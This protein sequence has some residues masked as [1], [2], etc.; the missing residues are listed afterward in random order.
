MVTK[1][2]HNLSRIHC[3]IVSLYEQ[4]EL[5]AGRSDIKH[6]LMR[7]VHTGDGSL[8][9][10]GTG[11]GL[12]VDKLFKVYMTQKFLFFLSKEH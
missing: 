8:N 11:T 1:V 9:N 5:T 4:Q 12:Q 7:S 2:L 3:A 6:H 10:D